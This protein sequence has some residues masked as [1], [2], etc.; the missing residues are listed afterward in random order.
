MSGLALLVHDDLATLATARRALAA[1]GWAVVLATSA[2]D[3]V[4]TFS[5]HHPPL[6]TC[7]GDLMADS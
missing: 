3:A 7:Q 1:E 5:Q 2:S 6:A 4:I